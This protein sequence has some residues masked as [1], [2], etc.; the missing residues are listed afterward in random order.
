[1]EPRETVI[2]FYEDED[3]PRFKEEQILEKRHRIDNNDRHDVDRYLNNTVG[4]QDIFD[5]WTFI[6]RE[7]FS[8][9][10]ED[11]MHAIKNILLWL[12]R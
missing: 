9:A 7:W 11:V 3:D 12:L 4:H 5:N 6:T 1:M 10:D 2:Q 8:R